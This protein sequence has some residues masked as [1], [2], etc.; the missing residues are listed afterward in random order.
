MVTEEEKG[1]DVLVPSLMI[2][3]Q[4][5]DEALHFREEE[6]LFAHNLSPPHRLMLMFIY[7]HGL[8]GLQTSVQTPPTE[9]LNTLM[10][11]CKQCLYS[12]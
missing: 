11:V 8:K 1:P 9:P 10:L 12:L 6:M 5:T 3:I 7:S 4:R 2:G